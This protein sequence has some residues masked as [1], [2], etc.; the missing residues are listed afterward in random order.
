MHVLCL[1]SAISDK[2][3]QQTE[4]RFLTSKNHTSILST[5]ALLL[6]F[7]KSGTPAGSTFGAVMCFHDLK[8][9]SNRYRLVMNSEDDDGGDMTISVNS[10]LWN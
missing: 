5:D 7:K 9:K 6:V 4:E 8:V 10:F 2:A 3:V 1:F